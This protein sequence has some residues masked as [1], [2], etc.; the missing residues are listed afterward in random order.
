MA[1]QDKLDA[2]R[3]G[4]KERIPADVLA[5]MGQ[6]TA[7]LKGSGILDRVVKPGDPAPE[8]EL[9]NIRGEAVSSRALL[10]K[11]PLV[12]TFYRGFW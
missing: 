6:A 7:D 4:A 3:E 12:A 2:M 11:G 1:L 10:A 8:F 5:R 9:N